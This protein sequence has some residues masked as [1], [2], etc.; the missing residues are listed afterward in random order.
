[1]KKHY[2]KKGVTAGV[3]CLLILVSFPTTTCTDVNTTDD[4]QPLDDWPKINVTL[5]DA[6][7]H[8]HALKFRYADVEFNDTETIIDINLSGITSEYVYLGFIQKVYL[9]VQYQIKPVWAI[10]SCFLTNDDG[11][12]EAMAQASGVNAF[13]NWQVNMTN[14]WN[15]WNVSHEGILLINIGLVGAPP[16]LPL[17]HWLH[18]AFD[19]GY[20]MGNHPIPL[21]KIFGG[22]ATYQAYIHT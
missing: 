19:L 17:L 2:L 12:R 4:I 15:N 11:Y 18:I 3:I 5:P 21:L 6:H 16:W 14:K 8:Y 20:L 22:I 10:W 13:H 7:L 1:M 9:H